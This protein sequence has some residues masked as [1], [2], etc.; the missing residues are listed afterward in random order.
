MMDSPAAPP[1]SAQTHTPSLLCSFPS[2]QLP[3]ASA[4]DLTYKLY[5]L[6]SA[7]L[8]GTIATPY[9][10]GEIERIVE[11]LAVLNNNTVPVLGDPSPIEGKWC[12]QGG[13]GVGRRHTKITAFCK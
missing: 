2:S 9:Q 6:C 10:R 8:R 12:V 3:A 11:Q 1:P 4:K 7:T 5:K 13:R